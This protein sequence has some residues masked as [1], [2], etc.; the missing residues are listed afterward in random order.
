MFLFRS[1]I[2]SIL[3][4]RCPQSNVVRRGTDLV[5]LVVHVK[6]TLDSINRNRR[7]KRENDIYIQSC[8]P[9][10]ERFAP[11]GSVVSSLIR[12]LGR[13]FVDEIFDFVPLAI[14]FTNASQ[15]YEERTES[16]RHIVVKKVLSP[17][18][19]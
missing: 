16:C 12:L 9:V 15:Y 5:G 19:Y 13:L 3:G 14:L 1:E 10:A 7:I 8:A 17:R 2:F 11:Q 4:E 18:R 6:V